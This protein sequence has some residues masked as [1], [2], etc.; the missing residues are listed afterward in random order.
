MSSTSIFSPPISTIQASS[1]ASA[2]STYIPPFA[3]TATFVASSATTHSLASGARPTPTVT[4]FPANPSTPAFQDDLDWVSAYLL[5]HSLSQNS[6]VYAYIFWFAIALI[7]SLLSLLHNAGARG[8]VLGAWWSKWALRRRTWRK[9]VS[10]TAHRQPWSLPSNAQLLS[11]VCL[12]LA[13]AALCVVGPNY[14][15]PN[16][17]LFNFSVPRK[18]SKRDDFNPSVVQIF[19]AQYTIPK[20]IWSSAARAGAVAV[21]LLPLTV[22]LALKAPPFAIFAI[23][24]T[25]QFHFDKLFRLHRWAGRLV[26]LAV[27]VHVVL[28]CIE[29]GRNRRPSTGKLVWNYVFLYNKFIFGWVVSAVASLTAQCSDT[30]F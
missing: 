14:L 19:Q 27:L 13:V 30:H 18:I 22:L 1:T 6:Y 8:G 11:V 5:I 20:S 3:T 25:A 24:Y 21:M 9:S 16:A 12:S 2:V 26:W 29:L 23:P 15:N 17:G 28:W 10:Q 7:F 4:G